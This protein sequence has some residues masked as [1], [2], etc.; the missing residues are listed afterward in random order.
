MI[1]KKRWIGLVLFLSLVLLPFALEPIQADDLTSFLTINQINGSR[2]LLAGLKYWLWLQRTMTG[3]FVPVGWT[4][5][6]FDVTLLS[7][8]QQITHINFAILYFFHNFLILIPTLLLTIYI[9]NRAIYSSQIDVRSLALSSTFGSTLILGVIL[10]NHSTWSM[11][12][13]SQHLV[14]GLIGFLFIAYSIDAYIK[15]MKS[16]DAPIIYFSRFLFFFTLSAFIYDLAYP[17]TLVSILVF[18][19]RSRK[20]RSFDFYHWSLRRSLASFA[21]I[22]STFFLS[23]IL[24]GNVD[25]A[26]TQLSITGATIKA[27]SI[28][29]TSLLPPIG[30]ARAIRSYG[31]VP[32]I[33][34][35]SFCVLMC[36]LII[37][38]STF[39]SYSDRNQFFLK[40]MAVSPFIVEPFFII[41]G[42]TFAQVSNKQWVN[43]MSHFGN[44]YLYELPSEILLAVMLH[45]FFSYIPQKIHRPNL[46][47]IR[48]V[49]FLLF[50]T[51]LTVNTIS[52]WWVLNL[53][54]RQADTS[55]VRAA[56]DPHLSNM[57]GCDAV[58]VFSKIR[59]PKSYQDLVIA[60]ASDI[61]SKKY[62]SPICNG[63]KDIY[64][65]RKELG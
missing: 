23:Q 14:Y 12:P 60:T 34:V 51:L 20:S 44:I 18:M 65:S 49:L 56:L 45:Q 46:S 16:I 28:G 13:F 47:T 38:K 19:F 2:G 26:G 6:W 61:H 3:H 17:I 5:Q 22:F 36:I 10:L 57:E 59:Y 11:D 43:V 30:I 53:D 31:N 64:E 24:R 15:F 52:N 7:S 21:V 32:H 1:T 48:I 50:A 63:A 40:A 29:M 62:G 25:Y 35:V 8:V 27:T 41:L 4:I 42:A 54:D 55:I 37:L 58:D 9:I 39:F 33:S